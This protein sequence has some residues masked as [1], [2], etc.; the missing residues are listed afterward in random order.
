MENLYNVSTEFPQKSDSERIFEIGL[1]LPKLQSKVTCLVFSETVCN[2]Y[3]NDR[4]KYCYRLDGPSL[5]LHVEQ[6]NIVTT[7][8]ARWDQ[9]GASQKRYRQQP[10]R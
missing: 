10:K 3:I 5:K 6:A 4:L 7:A 8:V 2:R 1:Y 9:F